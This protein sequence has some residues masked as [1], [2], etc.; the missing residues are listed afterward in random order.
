MK[1]Q[2]IMCDKDFQNRPEVGH[3]IYHYYFEK[4]REA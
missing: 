3:R 4:K 1:L 2:A